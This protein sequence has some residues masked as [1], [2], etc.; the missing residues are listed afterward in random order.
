[1]LTVPDTGMEVTIDIGEPDNIY[2][3]NKQDAGK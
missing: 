2:P 1:M 3:D